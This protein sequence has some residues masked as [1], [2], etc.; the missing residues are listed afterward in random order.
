M[1]LIKIDSVRNIL[2]TDLIL[3]GVKE[4]S[5]I[6]SIILSDALNLITFNLL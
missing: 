4:F 2:Q 6:T 5:Q 1:P 3:K